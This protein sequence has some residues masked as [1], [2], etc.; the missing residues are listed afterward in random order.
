MSSFVFTKMAELTLKS[1]KVLLPL[2]SKHNIQIII[3]NIYIYIDIGT[4]RMKIY[5]IF[6]NIIYNY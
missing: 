5:N 3:Q 4:E 1:L 2:F 6:N